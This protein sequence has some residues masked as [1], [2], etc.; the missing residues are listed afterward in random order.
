MTNDYTVDLRIPR[1]VQEVCQI[2]EVNTPDD[3]RRMPAHVQRRIL[4]V[5]RQVAPGVDMA[6]MMDRRIYT[7]TDVATHGFTRA[8]SEGQGK[9]KGK[10]ILPLI[11]APRR[12][13]L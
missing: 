4:A 9:G 6:A 7:M 13:N 1:G 2:F 8:L 3:F 11:D 5:M 12:G 10:G